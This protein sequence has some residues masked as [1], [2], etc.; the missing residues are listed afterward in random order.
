[1]VICSSCPHPPSKKIDFS[2][3]KWGAFTKQ[4]KTFKRKEP[5]SSIQNLD[6]FADFI[7]SHPENFKETTLKRAR[8]YKNVIEKKGGMS[9]GES[10]GFFGNIKRAFTDTFNKPATKQEKDIL[11]PIFQGEKFLTDKLITPFA[12]PAGKIADKQREFLEN[13]Y[14]GEGRNIKRFL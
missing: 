11:R 4:F 5:S 8:F 3:I 14:L 10:L 9:G 7:I 1:M 6:E 12:P 2:K 13:K